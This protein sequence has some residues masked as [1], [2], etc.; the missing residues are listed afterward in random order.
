MHAKVFFILLLISL[1]SF[2][3]QND[4]MATLKTTLIEKGGKFS[5]ND[6]SYE[7]YIDL[8]NQKMKDLNNE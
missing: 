4:S 2:L 7:L 5:V 8:V 6:S 3:R 1:D